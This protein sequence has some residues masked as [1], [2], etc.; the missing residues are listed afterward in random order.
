MSHDLVGLTSI[1]VI[2]LRQCLIY[3]ICLFHF[4]SSRFLSSDG[5]PIQRLDP[6]HPSLTAFDL[7]YRWEAVQESDLRLG[8]VAMFVIT[9]L[10]LCFLVGYITCTYDRDSDPKRKP[11]LSGGNRVAYSA[12]RRD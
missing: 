4:E 9:L 10:L 7:E 2:D 6:Q 8:V 1:Y 5:S 11:T 12:G 3:E